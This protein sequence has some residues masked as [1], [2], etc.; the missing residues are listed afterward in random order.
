MVKV[1]KAEL[2]QLKYRVIKNAYHD[3]ALAYKAREW[4]I[5]R[6]RY[7]LGIEIPSKLPN[8]KKDVTKETKKK[9]ELELFKYKKI[10]DKLIY[11]DVDL[12]EVIKLANQ[13]KKKS[14][15]NIADLIYKYEHIDDLPEDN[16]WGA[17]IRMTKAE[18]VDQWVEWDKKDNDYPLEF[19][20]LAES[21]NLEKGLDK[22]HKLGWA[23]V[24]QAFINNQ[25]V[26]WVKQ[27][28][29]KDEFMPEL[30]LVS[31]KIKR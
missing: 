26:D 22:D 15:K 4:S 19:Q 12:E 31:R 27:F 5:E 14:Y 1:N 20:Y 23:V 17:Y 6:I 24:Y 28:Y 29:Q 13:Y 11:Y 7:E 21:I 10:R 18:R 8:L 2:R 9:K 16:L 25:D 30:Y 3:T